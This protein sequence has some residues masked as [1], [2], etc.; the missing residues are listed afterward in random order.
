[1]TSVAFLYV[2]V[3]SY[4]R[5]DCSKRQRMFGILPGLLNFPYLFSD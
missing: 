3:K 4:T 2:K 5:A 1:M